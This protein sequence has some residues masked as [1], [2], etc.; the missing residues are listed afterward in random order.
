MTGVDLTPKAQPPSIA[1]KLISGFLGAGKTTYLNQLIR[2]QQFSAE[3]VILVNDFGAINI[4]VGP[5]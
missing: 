5:D 4:D 2:Q 3:T 1:L